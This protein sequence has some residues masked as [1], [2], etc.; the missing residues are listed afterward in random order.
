MW[1]WNRMIEHVRVDMPSD[2]SVT[3]WIGALK[4]QDDSRASGQLYARYIERLKTVARMKLDS[5]TR[6]VA[7]EEDVANMALHSVF[8]GIRNDRFQQLHDRDDLWQIL[9]MLV[10][11]KATDLFRKDRA[12]KRGAG[13]VR[14]ESVFALPAGSDSGDCGIDCVAAPDPTPEYAALVLEEFDQRLEQLGSSDLREIAVGKMDGLTNAEI[15]ERR[16]CSQRTVE[17]KLIL[18]R[19][20]W[21]DEQERDRED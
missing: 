7:D 4:G 20:I 18:I 3:H 16:G 8:C 9:L 21:Q 14:G 11:R 19:R 2:A 17:R 12:K 13:N 1:P 6:R 15:A 10:D 5:R